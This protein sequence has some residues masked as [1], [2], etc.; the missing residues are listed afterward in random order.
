MAFI[1]CFRTD[2]LHRQFASAPANHNQASLDSEMPLLEAIYGSDA[3]EFLAGRSARSETWD[4]PV[5]IVLVNSTRHALRV[6][7]VNYEGEEQLSAHDVALSAEWRQS[8][9]ETHWFSVRTSEAAQPLMVLFRLRESESKGAS[10]SNSVELVLVEAADGSF[11]LQTRQRSAACTKVARAL[12]PAADHHHSA[13]THHPPAARGHSALARDYKY[14][15]HD[16]CGWQVHVNAG[17]DA[18]LTDRTLGTMREDLAAVRELLPPAALATVLTVHFYVNAETVYGAEGAAPVHGRGMCFHM[19]PEW[20][21]SNG[22]NPDKAGAIEIY[23]A[24]DYLDW[25][26]HQPVMLLHELSHAYHHAS[27]PALDA[28]IRACFDAAAAS[29][30]YE[31]VDYVCTPG[32]KARAYA[33][34]NHTEFFAELS[35]AF[36][37]R[38][39]YFPFTRADLAAFDPKAYAMLR[40]AWGAE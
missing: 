12:A 10:E 33:L 28:R 14:A 24:E 21:S 20:L 19:S 18:A 27:G 4:R 16:V 31:A 8:S 13:A 1:A 40:E 32:A 36:W 11:S 37:G 30:R 2:S 6:S 22:N 3:S 35:E 34:T 17:M 25:R 39:D 38:N 5:S 23:R 26:S 15:V 9:F 7:W 29:G